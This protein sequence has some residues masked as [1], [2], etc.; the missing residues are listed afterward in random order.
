MASFRH[1]GT[2]GVLGEGSNRFCKV[3]LL[4]HVIQAKERAYNESFQMLVDA[5]AE[6]DDLE[7]F[8]EEHDAD[9]AERR[10]RSSSG[11][12]MYGRQYP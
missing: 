7:F 5:R 4:Y 9:E 3:I 6:F 12:G 8:Y 2:G 10:P 1:F 11:H